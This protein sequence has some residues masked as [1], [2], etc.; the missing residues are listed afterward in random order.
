MLKDFTPPE[1]NNSEFTV[2][3]KLRNPNRKRS[4]PSNHHVSGSM[5]R[6][7]GVGVSKNRGGTPK[8]SILIGF[9]IIF[10]IHFGGFTT[11]F[12]STHVLIFDGVKRCF[13]VDGRSILPDR[14]DFFCSVRVDMG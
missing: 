5:L 14:G 13:S 10:T 2:N 6:L 11:I 1:F 8:S 12:G 4:E 3:E 9:F 7:G